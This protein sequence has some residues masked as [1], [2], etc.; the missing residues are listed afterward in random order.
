MAHPGDPFDGASEIGKLLDLL[1]ASDEHD[2][3]AEPASQKPEQ[4][5]ATEPTMPVLYASGEL[6]LDSMD[7]QEN[8]FAAHIVQGMLKMRRGRDLD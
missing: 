4:H 7:T 8:K 2:G 3:T 1:N 5:Q 6:A